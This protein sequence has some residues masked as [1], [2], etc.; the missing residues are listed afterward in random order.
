[1][2]WPPK[3]GRHVQPRGFCCMSK[4]SKQF[5]LKVVKEFLKSGGLKRVGLTYLR[6]GTLMSVNGPWPIK[7]MAIVV[8]IPATN[9]ILRNLKYKF[10]NPWHSIRYQLDQLP[11]TLGL[12]VWPRFCNGKNST[13]KVVLQPS[14][15]DREDNSL[16]PNLISKHYSKS[17]S[18]NSR[19]QRCEDV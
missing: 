19:P 17:L 6:L 13:M 3:V 9:A 18:Q 10:S 12:G 1:M 7:H 5:K 14:P 4:Y 16:C 11:P 2:N 15:I 8:S